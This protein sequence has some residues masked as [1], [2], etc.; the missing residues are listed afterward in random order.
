MKQLEKIIILF[1]LV[2]SVNLYGNDLANREKE[3][4]KLKLQG[5]YNKSYN[6]FIQLIKNREKPFIL[7]NIYLYTA[8][9]LAKDFGLQK[10]YIKFL[11]EFKKYSRHKIVENTINYIL[12][13]NYL[14]TSNIT[15][16]K[17][18]YKE[19]GFIKKWYILGP[20]KNED[21]TGLEKIFS[22]EYEIN[23]NKYYTDSTY[24][25]I[26]FRRINTAWYNGIDIKNYFTPYKKSVA[27][28]LTYIYSPTNQFLEIHTGSDDGI[29][30]WVNDYP[31]ISNDIY[32]QAFF[33]Q[34]SKKVL[35]GKGINKILVKIT[36]DQG[37]WKFFFRIAPTNYI[38]TNYSPMLKNYTLKTQHYTNTLEYINKIKN[39]FF[40]KGYCYLINKDYP[41]TKKLDNE[42]FYKAYESDKKNSLY[43]LYV[44]ISGN[45]PT[46]KKKYLL[47]SDKNLK[48][49]I[50][51]KLNLAQYY[52][53]LKDFDA[54]LFYLKK[55]PDNYIP[56]ELEK[57]S[58]LHRKNLI[59]D[60]LKVIDSVLNLQHDN[61]IALF[62]KGLF[63]WN[64]DRDKS[65]SNIST[66]FNIS[67][68]SYPLTLDSKLVKYTIAHFG[69]ILPLYKKKLLFSNDNINLY[70]ELSKYYLY[71]NNPLKAL[72]YN[73]TALNINPY[74]LDSLN[75]NCDINLAL[76][77]KKSAVKSLKKILLVTPTDNTVQKRLMYLTGRQLNVLKKFQPKLNKITKQIFSKNFKYYKNKYK[78]YSAVMFLDSKII[79]LSDIGTKEKIITKIYYILSSSAKNRYSSDVI[80]YSPKT[81]KIDILK[82]ATIT[83]NGKD[84]NSENI[85]EHSIVK[86]DEKLYYDYVAKIIRFSNVG[87]DTVIILQYHSWERSENDFN[88]NYFNDTVYWGSDIPSINK[89]YT[90]IYPKYRNM[91]YK[92]YNFKNGFPKLKKYNY[93]KLRAYSWSAKNLNI[94]SEEE[95]MP[96]IAEIIPQIKI[97]TFDNWNKVNEWIYNLSKTSIGMNA[98]M[99]QL[100]ETVKNKNK[101]TIIET[102]YNYVRDKIRY[103]GIELGIGGIKPRNSISVFT[104]K[105]G[106]CKDKATLLNSL[107]NYAGI[108]SYLGLVRT[109]DSGKV[110]YD[111]P[112][113]SYFNHAISIVKL[114][115]KYLF[116]DATA[117][118]FKYNELPYSDK[119]N[120]IL[121]INSHKAKFVLPPKYNFKN[122]VSSADVTM[123]IND[124]LSAELKYNIYRKGN[125]APVVRYIAENKIK[126]KKYIESTWN[127]KYPGTTL[128]YTSYDP[129]AVKP[130]F[131]YKVFIR[132]FVR[133]SEGEFKFKPLAIPLD[134]YDTYCSLEKRKYDIIISYPYQLKKKIYINLFDDSLKIK[135][136]KNLYIDNSL[137]LYKIRFKKINKS[138]IKVIYTMILK[139]RRVKKRY[140]KIFKAALQKIKEKENEYIILK[141]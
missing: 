117:N 53:S 108:K 70:N 101:F 74:N 45:Q 14:D 107:L 75:L 3:A 77:K 66:V 12:M 89:K 13:L 1:V 27:Y 116:L 36:Q 109:S 137:L 87:K 51:A 114:G 123:V 16:I 54:S 92:Y 141:K 86:P 134:L 18:I 2:F 17:N 102:L 125:F 8:N 136:P 93:N 112:S 97:T 96:P 15:E 11:R 126:H 129:D 7:N 50:A 83:R 73:K 10:K 4:F 72:Y 32:R 90:V 98:E 33:E 113:V 55:I 21:R 91:Y 128:L 118:Y 52:K 9:F 95:N 42:N 120:K 46:E 68:Y 115:N 84:F 80:Y 44:A 85:E 31:V 135:L 139:K 88:K 100:V 47:L 41:D 40:Y 81:T 24:Y 119:L 130:N 103:V 37:D 49:N 65:Y 106:D 104:S 105:Y 140:Y 131:S 61:I 38:V 110:K 76:N 67:P 30:V 22:P 69:D 59:P 82:A 78:G 56:A 19:L 71:S 99:K 57:A 43:A 39:N 60:S 29:K 58:I 20:F 23:L 122:N 62:L 26:K 6:K 5:K 124:D 64:I 63:L 25:P 28:F 111:T 35:F 34:D 133:K 94:L 138:K 127:S 48:N 121:M 79:N 132:N